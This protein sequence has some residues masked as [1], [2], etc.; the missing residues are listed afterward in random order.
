MRNLHS[1]LYKKGS[2]TRHDLAS[3]YSSQEP[4]QNLICTDPVK[5]ARRAAWWK[6]QFRKL[7]ST[8]INYRH[9]PPIQ[10]CSSLRKLQNP[11]PLP[12]RTT[13]WITLPSPQIWS[14]LTHNPKLLLLG[15]PHSTESRGWLAP[16]SSTVRLSRGWGFSTRW[17]SWTRWWRSYSKPV[18]LSVCL[19]ASQNYKLV[20][21]VERVWGYK[22]ESRVPAEEVGRS[23]VVE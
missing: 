10:Q 12:L 14:P 22:Y 20:P 8:T 16:D 23:W 13:T 7:P 21:G 4:Q 17:S 1:H 19:S 3:F 5:R 11:E 15:L 6:I 2:L 18:W 9:F